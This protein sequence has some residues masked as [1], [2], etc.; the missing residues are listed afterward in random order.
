LYMFVLKGSWNQ[1]WRSF[2][3]QSPQLFA[4]VFILCN[5]P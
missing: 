2:A 1:A 4:G 5:Q 3:V